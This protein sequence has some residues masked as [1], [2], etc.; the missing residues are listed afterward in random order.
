MPDLIFP[1][2]IDSTML[3]CFRACPRK[4]FY[5]FCMRMAPAKISPDLHAGGAFAAGMEAVR[6][7]LYQDNLALEAALLKGVTA[8]T[9]YWG[10]Y[11]PPE[12]HVKTYTNMCNALFDYFEHYAPEREH[13]VPLM[14]DGKPAVEFR[15]AHPMPVMHPVTKEPIVFAG[16]F[17]MLGKM[18]GMIYI[19]DEKTTKRFEHN[20]SR[21]WALRSQFLGYTWACREQG[22]PVEGAI[23]R[24]IAIL[25]SEFKH[26][27]AHVPMPQWQLDRWYVQTIRDMERM[28]ACW[29][30]LYFDMNYGE[31]CSSYGGCQFEILC[32]AQD[33]EIWF[34]DFKERVWNPLARDPTAGEE[35]TNA[36]Q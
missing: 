11:E 13:F 23:V 35:P 3:T 31:S 8:L 36:A 14:T 24:G 16:R 6:R 12:G 9:R 28:V 2:V 32:T 21:Q 4:F 7:A 22:I 29:Q 27:E 30:G 17:D 34:P 20:W 5:E 18:A 10:D 19:G 25:K 26:L 1:N 15:F 33:P